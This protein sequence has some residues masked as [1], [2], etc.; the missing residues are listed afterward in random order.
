MEDYLVAYNF[1]RLSNV[2]VKSMGNQKSGE[3]IVNSYQDVTHKIVVNSNMKWLVLVELDGVKFCSWM[4][5]D[6]ALI[7]FVTPF[8]LSPSIHL[9]IGEH[10]HFL[11]HDLFNNEETSD[12]LR[13]QSRQFDI[14][15][16][17]SL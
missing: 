1:V 14:Y 16:P 13:P 4:V 7:A 5:S 8:S 2:Q 12:W 3:Q 6:V 10:L 11:A 15:E 9:A 17:P